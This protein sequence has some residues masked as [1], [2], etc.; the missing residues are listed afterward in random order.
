L[1]SRRTDIPTLRTVAVIDFTTVT[2]EC[3]EKAQRL[4]VKLIPYADL[5]SI[6]TDHVSPTHQ[7]TPDNLYII[8]YTSGTTGLPKGYNQSP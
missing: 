1:L 5:L 6:G 3:K 4:N 8:C 7:P 2:A